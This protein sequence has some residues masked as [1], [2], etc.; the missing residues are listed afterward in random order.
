[1]LELINVEGLYCH[2]MSFIDDDL[3]SM[4][5]EERKKLYDGYK[6]MFSSGCETPTLEPLIKGNDPRVNTFREK[7]REWFMVVCNYSFSPYHFGLTSYSH[8]MNATYWQGTKVK[9]NKVYPQRVIL[10]LGMTGIFTGLKTNYLHINDKAQDHGREYYVDLDKL[11]EWTMTSTEPASNFCET[12]T[13]STVENIWTMTSSADSDFDYSFVEKN[14][15]ASRQSWSL[16]DDWFSVRQYVTISSLTVIPECYV[17]ACQFISTCTYKMLDAVKDKDKK[18]DLRG[19]YRNC[20]WLINIHNGDVGCC[21]VDDKG[22]RYYSMMVCMGKDYRRACL[23]LD[24]ERIVEVDVSSSQPTL[25]GLKI[26][27][28]TG[29]TT[30]WLKHCLSG[31]F[32]EWVK[33]LT[34]VKVERAKVKTYIMRYLFSCYGSGLPKN[35]QREHL[36]PDSKDYKRGYKKFEQNLTG[37]LKDNEPE[38]YDLIERNKRNPVW[39]DKTWTDNWKK[40]RKGK[41]C[42]TLPVLMQKTEVEFIKTC[43]ARLPKDM[44]FFT[45]HDAICVKES[46]GEIVKAVMEKVSQDLY[47]EVIS[48]KIENSSQDQV[49]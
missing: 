7:F 36:P 5:K 45:I 37:Y 48:V 9:G 14:D 20:Q 43:L 30:E 8:F 25:I 35:I 38:I 19:R 13:S 46:D 49:K 23:Q 40:K 34:G 44:K 12:I 4:S 33:D 1:M 28:D 47:G 11:K 22:G 24:G 29:K 3:S 2:C 27:K 41:W 17:R 18:K 6:W 26:K 31:D 39:T 16:Y 15:E 32:Y 42:S 21:K 10:L